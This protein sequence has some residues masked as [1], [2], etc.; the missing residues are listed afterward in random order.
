MGV[1]FVLLLF[2]RGTPALLLYRGVLD[3][4]ERASLALMSRLHFDRRTAAM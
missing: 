4:R 1:F 3:A 2:V